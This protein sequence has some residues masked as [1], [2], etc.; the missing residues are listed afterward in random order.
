MK[1]F[2]LPIKTVAAP[3]VRKPDPLPSDGESDWMIAVICKLVERDTASGGSEFGGSGRMRPL[4]TATLAD[5]C[6]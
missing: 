3:D 4:G 1:N 6:H 5:A 2:N